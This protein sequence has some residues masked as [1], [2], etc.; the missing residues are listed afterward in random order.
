MPLLPS[1]DLDSHDF[2]DEFDDSADDIPP[3]PPNDDDGEEGED[4]FA[5]GADNVLFRSKA[6]NTPTGSSESMPSS[7]NASQAKSYWDPKQE[8]FYMVDPVT[9]ESWWV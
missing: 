8:A 3:P 1:P 6:A 9:G 4:G 2:E 7:N 5:G